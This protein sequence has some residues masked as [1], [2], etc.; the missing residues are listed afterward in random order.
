[1]AEDFERRF[2]AKVKKTKRCW[3]WTG[4]INSDGYGNFTFTVSRR[5]QRQRFVKAH[6]IAWAIAFRSIPKG[7]QVLHHC[8]NPAC[9]RPTHLFLG[10]H[11]DNMRDMEFKKRSNKARGSR[12]GRAIFTER[13]VRALRAEWMTGVQAKQLSRKYNIPTSTMQYI[14]RN[15]WRHV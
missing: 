6:R 2:W 3:V 11:T 13:Q 7:K 1:M 9:V 4:A 8:D 14:L 5:G 10:T 15:G 12:H